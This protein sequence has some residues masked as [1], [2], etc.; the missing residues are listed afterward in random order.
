MLQ[1]KNVNIKT[2]DQKKLDGV[3][4]STIK[5]KILDIKS[6]ILKIKKIIKIQIINT[7]VLNFDYSD[8]NYSCLGFKD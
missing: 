5:N 6:E 3:S 2:T 4:R 1:F 8:K 7:R